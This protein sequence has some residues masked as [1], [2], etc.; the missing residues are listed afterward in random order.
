MSGMSLQDVANALG[1]NVTRQAIHRYEQGEVIPD[2]EMLQ[3]L[4]EVFSVRPDFFFRDVV[5]DIGSVEYRKLTKLPAKEE[6]KIIEQ[7]RDYLSRYIELEQIL[8]VDK[9]FVNPLGKVERIENQADIDEA[10]KMVRKV[11]E[12][13]EDNHIKVV[14]ID[15]DMS[16]DG[17]QTWVNGKIPVVAFNVRKIKKTDRIRFTLLHELAHLLLEKKFG[18]ITEKQKEDFCHQFAGSM[19]LPKDTLI[20]ELGPKRAKILIPELKYLKRQYGISMQ[21]I[22]MRAHVCGIITKSYK[23]Q[24]FFLLDQMNWRIDEPEEYAGVE[25]SAHFDQLIY[26][27]IAEELISI[28]KAASL[29]NKSVADFRTEIQFG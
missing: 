21:A 18:K 22:V 20:K 12:M 6:A 3:R 28:S 16:F 15:A 24:F 23:S 11:S 2:S 25:K 4:C 7:T 26:R 17:L 1:N 29:K 8:G 13:L 9:E 19:L 14:K 10:A 27:G 5:V